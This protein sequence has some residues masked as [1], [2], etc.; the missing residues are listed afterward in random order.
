MGRFWRRF[1]TCAHGSAQ[2]PPDGRG[3]PFATP[4]GLPGS[5]SSIGGPPPRSRR[6]PGRAPPPGPLPPLRPLPQ[7]TPR[8]RPAPTPQPGR[9]PRPRRGCSRPRPA[10]APFLP[11]AAGGGPAPG[12]RRRAEVRCHRRGSMAAGPRGRAQSRRHIPRPAPPP[13]PSGGPAPAPTAAAGLRV[14]GGGPRAVP[15]APR[16]RRR[17]PGPRAKQT[18]RRPPRT[19][20]RRLP[21]TGADPPLAANPR[22]RATHPTA[23]PANRLAAQSVARQSRGAVLLAGLAPPPRPPPEGTGPQPAANQNDGRPRGPAYRPSL[24]L[25]PSAHPRRGAPQPERGAAA[26]CCRPF[27]A[28][29]GLGRRCETLRLLPTELRWRRKRS[30]WPQPHC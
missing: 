18:A 22:R 14:A 10:Q 4:P 26:L 7:A 16:R 1:P 23:P 12:G 5:T 17:A 29:P 28:C 9:R 20:R 2:G 25:G 30:S 19:R 8:P 24:A 3:H 6:L 11:M 21:I 15:V 13:P 27:P